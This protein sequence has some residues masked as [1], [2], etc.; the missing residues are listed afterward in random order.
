M[1]RQPLTVAVVGATGVVGRTMIQVLHERDFPV[2]E[3]RLLAS[4]RS[5]GRTVSVRRPTRSRSRGRPRGLRRRRHRPLLGRCRHLAGARPGGGRPRR[6]VIDN[7][8][9]WRMEPG[10]PLVVS[11]GQPGR[12]RGPR[13][14]HRQPEL[15]ARC[16]SS[17]VADGPARRGRPGA[18]RRRHLPVRL[19]DRRRGHRRAGGPDPG[20]RRRRAEG[21]RPS[22]RTR[23]PSTPCPRSTSSSTNGYTKEEWKVVNENRK[24]LHLPDLRDLLHGRPRSRSSSATPRRST[25][26]R[27]TRSRP[28]GRASCSRAVPGVVVQDDPAAHDYPLATEAAGSDE[29]FVGPRP[30]GRVD[31]GRSRA[32]LLGRLRQPA[33]GRRHERRR[34][35]RGRSSSA[36]GWHRLGPRR[37]SVPGGGA[38]S[39]P[40]RDRGRAP[41]GARGDRRGG[42]GLHALPAPRDA[43]ARPC[44]ARA[45]PSTEVVF[46][47][48]GPGFN[49]DRQGRP[50]VGRAGD[51]L[52]KLLGVDRLAARGRLHHERRQVPAAGQPR[53]GARRD[54]RLRAVP[55]AP[56]RGA[57]PGGRRDPR[58]PLDG[59]VHARRPIT[60]AHG[61]VRPV[62]PDD[63]RPGR[64][65][66][67]HVPPG[68]RAAD[69]GHRARRAT[70]TSPAC[71]AAAR[72]TRRATPDASRR[73]RPSRRRRRPRAADGRSAADP[74]RRRRRP[75]RHA[76]VRRDRRPGSRSRR[77]PTS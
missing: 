53:P 20:P 1:N 74:T 44:P 13:G 69:A 38:S 14:D 36:A 29:I 46:V 43:H 23:S 67:R 66:L 70:P 5:A 25:S 32:R 68:R 6:T 61:T 27:A 2:G 18:G 28:S 21:S 15:L 7:S 31:P 39:R 54:R 65:G 60:Q 55:A 59:P 41:G 35:R 49:E 24:I 37:A 16:S 64:A 47:G 40:R 75:H 50:F 8:S 42:P 33:Q 19:G 22:T 52:V 45:T 11:P 4:G 17:P 71:P 26:R 63:G 62:D 30:A 10:I 51:L 56:A 72:R 34:D 76:A 77:P 48:E 12:P 9:A 3:L 73:A 57:R 58:A